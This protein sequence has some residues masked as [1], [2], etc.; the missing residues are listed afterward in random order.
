[1][2]H[3]EITVLQVVPS[4]L[5]AIVDATGFTKLTS[6]RRVFTAGEV[7]DA[8]LARRFH[9]QSAAELINGYGPTETT[10]YST[11]WRCDR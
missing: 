7:L 4:M 8:G 10:V 9:A 2:Q 5:Q 6:L 1:V 11:Y 3:Q